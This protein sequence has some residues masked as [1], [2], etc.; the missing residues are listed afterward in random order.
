MRSAAVESRGPPSRCSRTLSDSAEAHVMVPVTRVGLRRA[1]LVEV[2]RSDELLRDCALLRALAP[3]EADRLLG[4]AVAR[5]YPEGAAVYREGDD[6]Q[7]MFLVLRGEVRLS[8]GGGGVMFAVAHK[9]EVFGEAEL[10]SSRT[11]R[12]CSAVASGD[13]DVAALPARLLKEV[14]CTN[15]QLAEL[16]Q[17]LHGSRR[18]ATEE[19][20]DFINRW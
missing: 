7:D 18:A 10:V 13:A 3:G 16:F 8:A 2:C 19:L 12:T 20:A 14:A 1:T 5:R 4:G 6:G 9:G 11:V 17:R 15:A